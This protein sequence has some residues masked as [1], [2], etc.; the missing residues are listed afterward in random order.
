MSATAVT[1]K[2][3]G[4]GIATITLDDGKVN[5]MTKKVWDDLIKTLHEAEQ[6]PEIRGIIY[7]SGLK[8]PVFTAG[9]DITELYAPNTNA[10]RYCQFWL[11]QNIFLSHLAASPLLTMA[12]IKGAC[13][14]GGCALALC[15]D[16]RFVTKDV[17]SG[18][19][20]AR[21]GISVP[22]FWQR[23]MA[24]VSSPII[25]ERLCSLGYMLPAKELKKFGLADEI[26]DTEQENEE[27]A[28][29]HVATL[30]KEVPDAGRQI[31]KAVSRSALTDPWRDETRIREES[32]EKW[33]FLCSEPVVKGL[34]ATLARL[35]KK[36]AKI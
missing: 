26:F 27:A 23:M 36:P 17:T 24:H 22:P 11:S 4:Q 10:E 35:Q 16:F 15:C 33:P 6:D 30:L 32:D 21:I 34:G 12:A 2:K 31:S 5:I 1:L 13:P 14:A 9:N 7:R 8:K 3:L 28:F 18:L 20:E 29:R 19:N 25:A